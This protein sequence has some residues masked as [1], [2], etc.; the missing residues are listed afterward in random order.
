M[1]AKLQ[2]LFAP[3]VALFFISVTSQAQNY[4]MNGTPINDCS[5]FFIDPGGNSGSYGPN[6]NITT[7]ICPDNTTGT[8]IRLFFPNME[9]GAGDTLCFFDGNST[10]ATQLA[11]SWE[12]D[13]GSPVSVQATAA[14]PSGCLTIRFRS[15]AADQG[16]GWSA[17]ISCIAACQTILAELVTTTPAV[18]PADTGWIN[19]CPGQRVFFEGR[20]IYP[21]NG[22]V[23]NHSDFTTSFYWEFGDGV[24]AV[25][26]NVSHVYDEPGGYIAQLH[27]VDQFGCTNTNFI[28]QRVRISSRPT[29]NLGD[30][31]LQ[32]I[33][34]GDTVSLNAVVDT[35]LPDRLISVVP[36]PN[37]FQA[38]GA[39]SEAIP[40]PDGVG[41]VY[42]TSIV[43][44]QFSPGQ[45]LSNI[46]DLFGICVN[47][48]H[49]WMHDLDIFLTCPDGSQVI[50]QDQAFISDEVFLGQPNETDTSNP[51]PPG[52]GWDYCWTPTATQN[53]TQYSTAHPN[54]QSLPEGDYAPFESLTGFLGCPLNGEWILTVSDQWGSDNGWV[55]EW[56][57]NFNPEIFPNLETF[58]PQIVDYSWQP[59]NSIF[60]MQPDSIA[61]APTNPGSASYTFAIVDEFGCTYD[62]T[63]R[64][65]VLPATHPN[66]HSCGEVLTPVEDVLI[67]QNG[68]AVLDVTSTL[69]TTDQVTFESS[70]LYPISAANHPPSNP[71]RDTI[72]VNSL[73]PPT[74]AA[75]VVLQLERVCIDI[76]TIGTGDLNISLRS[77]TG[78]VIDLSSGNGGGGNNYTNTCFTP[79]APTS[80]TTG[81][82]PFTGTYR[83]EGNWNLFAGAPVN[84]NWIL[85]VSDQFAP[86]QWGRVNDWNITFNTTNNITYTWSPAQGL[87]CTN[88]PNPTA[89]PS[90][91]RT[92]TVLATDS[93]GC[94]QRD[95]VT[96]GVV[97][98]IEAPVVTCQKTG[99]GE[100]TFS[101]TQVDNF[102][103]YEVNVTT[104]GSSSGWQGPIS[105]LSYIVS[106]LSNDDE[107][108]IEVRVNTGG[109]SVN[110][111]IDSGTSDCIYNDCSLTSALVNTAPVSC[112]GGNDGTV[113]VNAQTAVPPLTYFI[114]NIATGQATGAFSG[115][116]AGDH[117][118]I[119]RDGEGCADTLS[120]NIM[121]PALL[122]AAVQI[123]QP[124][125][126]NNGSNGL[127]SVDPQ[128]GNGGYIINWNGPA[129]PNPGGV[130]AGTYMVTVTDSK[131]C[132]A[133]NSVILN[134]PPA[135]NVMLIEQAPNCF[136]TTDGSMEAIATGGT[137]VITYAWAHTNS[138]QPIQQNLA[139]G[140]YCVTATDANGCTVTACKTIASP[141][142][143]LIN[144]ITA[145]PVDCFGNNTGSAIVIAS[146]GTPTAGGEYNYAWN[147]AIQ[148]VGDTAVFLFAGNYMV[149]VTDNRGCQVNSSINVP[150]PPQL[151]AN[152]S[153]TNALCFEENS[154]TATVAPVGGVSPYTVRWESNATT[155]TINNLLADAYDVTVTDANG[156]V[157]EGLAN[158]GQ[159]NSAVS[160]A[161]AQSFTGCFGANDNEASAMP[162]GGTGFGYTYLWGNGQTSPTAVNLAPGTQFVTITDSNGCT[163][164]EQV[165]LVDWNDIAV[166]IIA[167]EPSCAG[168]S[169]G[170]MGINLFSGGAGT[171]NN[172][173]DYHF[174]WNTNS[175]NLTIQNL[176]GN[177]TYTV[178]VTDLQG[179][180]K[181][182]SRLLEE[183]ED[184]TFEL[185]H[186]DVKCHAGAD[187]TATVGNIQGSITGGYTFLWSANANNQTTETA[188]NLAAGTYFLTVTDA[189]GCS[190]SNQVQVGQPTALAVSL[191]PKGVPC[192]GDALG[193]IGTAVSGGVPGYTYLWSNAQQTTP[194]V[195]NLAAGTYTV[196][197]QDANGCELSAS[198]EVTQPEPIT[199]TIV[200]KDVNCYGD[201]NGSLTIVP[202][203]GSSPFQ[204]SLDNLNFSGSGVLIGLAANDYSVYVR[205]R[206]GCMFFGEST[207]GSPLEFMVNAGEDVTITMGDSINLDASSENG[208][209]EVLYTWYAPYDGTLS[210]TE[211]PSPE[212]LSTNTITFELYGVDENGC[213]DN[214]FVNIF[215]RKP[216]V[217]AVPTG[218]TPNGDGQND[219]LLVHGQEGT[220][221]H[222]FR[223]YDR[224]GELL[225][226]AKDFEVND[227][228]TGW[229]GLFGDQPM[230]GGVYLWYVDAEYVDGVRE[231]FKGQ[232]TLIR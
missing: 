61:A 71:Y 50:L 14:N 92:Y 125:S 89:S 183:P 227:V 130:P 173:A 93:Y 220:I 72:R 216:R 97:S 177:A 148:Q 78:T 115:I 128:G 196:T 70:P 163:A 15:D 156:C 42:E 25:G 30:D 35:I 17:Q 120:F 186:T 84:G 206:N 112:N 180:S 229:D 74:L 36:T 155:F 95:T 171:A 190:S 218:F 226:E 214:D 146:G 117:F 126:C 28:S 182:F 58:A 81:V 124:V 154:G 27:I 114:D 67:C 145:R 158:V 18:V 118:V 157:A 147:D 49:S 167:I 98:D 185:T 55:F 198:A 169:D 20:G 8:H 168:D 175:T 68:S 127:I 113:L 87:S 129:T 230:N 153:V 56:N 184:I 222:S 23:Y 204:Y 34:V 201:R 41:A 10:A 73:S 43:I 51:P 194:E 4:V 94:T 88:C 162:S 75:P 65:G 48:E 31:V 210:C 85:Q 149:T 99:S 174:L 223:V 82:A 119:V 7:T 166:N 211:C 141:P 104:N 64:V 135:L 208:A 106:G 96:V 231:V 215:I 111:V 47:M 136:N 170:Q 52:I 44:T 187:G 1:S 134:N 76:Q 138:T 189:N 207:V 192:F 151:V 205:D 108:S 107:V 9:L 131:G 86:L 83:P 179:C 137:G 32:D 203:G 225:Y 3:M 12:F 143:L 200:A 103:D 159:P 121:E 202:Q 13:A 195:E 228:N 16:A 219:R 160:V 181:V 224:W 217:L 191:S 45:I 5:G 21:Q 102:T 26:P 57:I 79:T 66:C 212:V 221:V 193:T 188:A 161:V 33:C 11:C 59:H 178:T 199:A 109:A 144:S 38:G 101:W 116:S 39:V 54:I 6:L 60:Y 2:M 122:T 62:T 105:D 142:Q 197:V 110:C 172:S 139:A 164:T 165:A 37:S 19:A 22:V 69:P 213:E 63:I 90:A 53:W 40:L 80:I 152:T 132:I 133:T 29:F 100:I 140:N 24:T 123:D 176:A 46:N 77:P 232:T 209:G 91:T 150:Q